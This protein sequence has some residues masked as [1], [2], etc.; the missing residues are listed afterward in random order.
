MIAE[1]TTAIPFLALS[2][3]LVALVAATSEVSGL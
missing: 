3:K 2:L 1:L